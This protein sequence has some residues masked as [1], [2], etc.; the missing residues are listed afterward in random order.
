MRPFLVLVPLVMLSGCA[1]YA[2]DYW[3]SK[4][5]LVAPQLTRYGLGETATRCV[6]ERLGEDLTVWQLRQLADTSERVRQANLGVHELLWVSKLVNDTAVAPAVE[7]ALG[8]CGAATR[9]AAA[10]ASVSQ[11]VAP[12]PAPST[13]TQ[14]SGTPPASITPSATGAS[15]WLN[16]GVAAT[17]QSI[18][19][20][21][22][23]VENGPG[24]RKG[25]FRMTN[26]EAGKPGDISYLLKIDCTAKTITPMGGRKHDASGAVI[27]EKAYG[28][29]WEGALPIEE[30]T[31]MEIAYRSLCA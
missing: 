9:I 27:E 19:V 7:K 10:P 31:V 4:P 24:F 16:L 12:V 29:D 14:A 21:A 6:A 18:S 22:S 1:G 26:P 20:D 23:S 3:R 11:P 25:W 15:V 17:G 5:G 2:A 30:G 13:S 8:G 28:P